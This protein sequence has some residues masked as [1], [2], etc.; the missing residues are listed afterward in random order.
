VAGQTTSTSNAITGTSDPVLYQ[1]ARY[2]MTSYKFSVPNGNYYVTLKFAETYPYT[3]IGGR[4]CNVRIEGLQVLSNFDVVAAAG[5]YRAIDF[6]FFTMVSDGLL[7]IDFFSV[8]GPPQINAIEILSTTAQPTPSPSPTNSFQDPAPTKVIEAE[9]GTLTPHMQ[10][11][12]DPNASGGQYI[13]D[14]GG[15]NDQGAADYQFTIPYVPWTFNAY[16]IWAR[17]WA[18]DSNSDS[19]YF[20]LDGA[21]NTVWTATTSSGWLWQRLPDPP[22]GFI[23]EQGIPHRFRFAVREPNFRIDVI[24]FTDRHDTDPPQW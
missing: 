3:S 19:V 18:Q 2:G 13:Y 9:S 11:G 20:S 10:A 14:P 7:S 15:P 24:L 21:P 8:V 23:I 4:V 6:T 12:S 22:D 1:T 17:V 5:R 16:I